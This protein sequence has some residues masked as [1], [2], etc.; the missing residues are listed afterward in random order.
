MEP[1]EIYNPIYIALAF[2]FMDKGHQV[3]LSATEDFKNFGEGFGVAFRPLWGNAETM[4][5][6]TEGESILQTENSIKLMKS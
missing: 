6:S 1:E 2:G 5:N 3:T 4:M